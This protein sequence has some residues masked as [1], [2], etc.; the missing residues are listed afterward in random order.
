MSDEPA[1][2]TRVEGRLDVMRVL[3]REEI[4]VSVLG[5]I[6]RVL[7]V[8]RRMFSVARIVVTA[9]EVVPEAG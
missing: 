7:I 8:E 6:Q 9:A 1:S 3:E 2:D 5:M 4:H